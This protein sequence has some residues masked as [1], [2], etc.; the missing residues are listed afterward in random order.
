MLPSMNMLMK[1][2]RCLGS[3][4]VVGF[5]SRPRLFQDVYT[6]THLHRTIHIRPDGTHRP[7]HCHRGTSHQWNRASMELWGNLFIA[8]AHVMSEICQ[9]EAGHSK[10]ECDSE[11]ETAIA[12]TGRLPDLS[13]TIMRKNLEDREWHVR[14][15]SENRSESREH[16]KSG[17]WALQTCHHKQVH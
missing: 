15:S 6:S 12:R 13:S 8:I 9:A 4:D 5:V 17:N 16:V 7:H 14:S 1:I 2:W 3:K 11:D 10:R